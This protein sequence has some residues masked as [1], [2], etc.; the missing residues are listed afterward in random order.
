MALPPDDTAYPTVEIAGIVAFLRD[1]EATFE[2]NPAAR[3]EF[4]A[5]VAGFGEGRGDAGAVAARAEE[6]LGG[7]P[8]VLAQFRACLAAPDG[9]DLATARPRRS[10]RIRPKAERDGSDGDADVV[11]D[12][13]EEKRSRRG[14]EQASGAAKRGGGVAHREE[15]E[16]DER[17]AAGSPEE[18][19]AEGR[20]RLLGAV[21]F[22]KHVKRV[23]RRRVYM[24][25]LEVLRTAARDNGAMPADALYCRL[26]AVLGPANHGLLQ[27]IAA[28]YLPGKA[29]WEEQEAART[30]KRGRADDEANVEGKKPRAADDGGGVTVN[31]RAGKAAARPGRDDGRV[32]ALW[33][34]ATRYSTLTSTVSRTEAMIAVLGDGVTG[35]C[36]LDLDTLFPSRDSRQLL[37]RLYGAQWGQMRRA[38]EDGA[39]AGRALRVVLDSLRWAEEAA[40]NEAMRCRDRA[41]AA[42]RLKVLLKNKLDEQRR[43]SSTARD[44]PSAR[45]CGAGPS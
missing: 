11:Y 13:R 7:R 44:G 20:G 31:R 35:T 5:L 21:A 2:S 45:S 1:V 27:S 8:R 43:R 19:D 38:I 34:F 14:R 36:S 37:A 25:L 10:C 30:K 4:F 22:V 18:E 3:G 16:D 41:R 15:E 26:R 39:V 24:N 9:D 6:I 12:Q 29:E 33:E 42:E 28:A 23:V 17:A 32:R 40:V